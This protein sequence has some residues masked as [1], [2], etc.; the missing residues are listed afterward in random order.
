VIYLM[1]LRDRSSLF[2]MAVVSILLSF[3]SGTLAKSISGKA[4]AAA[5]AYQ[6]PTETGLELA[7]RAYFQSSYPWH[8]AQS[9]RR[10]CP[11]PSSRF[12]QQDQVH[13][14][15]IGSRAGAGELVPNYQLSLAAQFHSNRQWDAII[16]G[17]NK[18]CHC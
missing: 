4:T 15:P 11:L 6:L 16:N 7:S 1:I 14:A 10:G 9:E 17:T 13:I 18:A 12:C 8:L 2:C 5:P 3:G